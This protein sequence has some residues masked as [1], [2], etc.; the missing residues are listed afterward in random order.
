MVKFQFRTVSL[1]ESHHNSLRS[2]LHSHMPPKDNL[3][4]ATHS[5]KPTIEEDIAQLTSLLSQDSL[6]ETGEAN[7]VELLQRLEAA[8]GVAKGVESRLDGILGN[9][10]NLLAT[11]ESEQA[12]S[13]TTTNGE[14]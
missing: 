11:L 3:N 4:G 8:E 9:L 7:V 13:T 12:S 6:D 1:S 2:I 10:D 14:K 5:A